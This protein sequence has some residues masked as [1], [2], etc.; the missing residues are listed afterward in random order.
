MKTPIILFLIILFSTF[1]VFGNPSWTIQYDMKQPDGSVKVVKV[2]VPSKIETL[3]VQEGKY[4]GR[5]GYIYIYPSRK[6]KIFEMSK[7]IYIS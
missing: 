4:S 3:W 2:S 6:L 1:K 7:N 5:L